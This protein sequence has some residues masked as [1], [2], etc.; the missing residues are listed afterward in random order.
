MGMN[1]VQV[2]KIEVGKQDAEM[3]TGEQLELVFGGSWMRGVAGAPAHDC[4]HGVGENPER[5]E[6]FVDGF[7]CF[8]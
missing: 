7:H 8:D 3:Q 1:P 4:C 6:V 5:C 2:E